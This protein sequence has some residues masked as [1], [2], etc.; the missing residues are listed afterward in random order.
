[1]NTQ[2]YLQEET[3]V[4]RAIDPWAGSYYVEYL[5]DRLARRAWALIEEVEAMGG[6]T[7]AIESGLPKL[8]IEEAAARK[9]ARIDAGH[10]VIVGVN[11]YRAAHEAPIDVL[12]VDNTAVRAR[13]VERLRALRA[14]RDEAAV[15][16]A[17]AALARCAETG[18]GNLLAAAVEAA[19]RR[20]TLGEISA[21]LE[22]P[23]GRYQAAI[24]TV[25]GA[26]AD[27][28]ARDASFERT[29]A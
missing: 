24:R 3:D 29:R 2:L 15:N 9:Q 1:R 16:D 26:Y 5:T 14:A 4:T 10:D 7:K 18:E 23:F 17:L 13:Q 12:E 20:A 21:A 25:S 28:V 22:K 6:M 11:R 27:E 8:R 19:R